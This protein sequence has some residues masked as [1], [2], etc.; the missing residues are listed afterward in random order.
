MEWL[1]IGIGDMLG[2]FLRFWLSQCFQSSYFGIGFI[3]CLGC[4]LL[5]ICQTM[6]VNSLFKN[7]L[8]IGFLGA[9]TTYSTFILLSATLAQNNL[10]H[11]F[12][13]LFLQIIL[14]IICLWAGYKLSF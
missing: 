14:G 12:A 2:T 10:L 9:F 6:T 11:G 7:V 1:L 8:T 3:N 13:Y 5:G 4:F